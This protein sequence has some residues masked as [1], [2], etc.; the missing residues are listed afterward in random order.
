MAPVYDYGLIRL[1]LNDLSMMLGD[2]YFDPQS[3]DFFGSYQNLLRVTKKLKGIEPSE[4]K[5]WL[6]QQDAYTLIDPS[7][8]DY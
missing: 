1:A 3:E 6:E 4:V 2:Q 8:S 5:P 7:E